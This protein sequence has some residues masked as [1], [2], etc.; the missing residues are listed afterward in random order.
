MGCLPTVPGARWQLLYLTKP[1]IVMLPGVQAEAFAA[2]LAKPDGADRLPHGQLIVLLEVGFCSDT[3]AEVK[4]QEKL[5]QHANLRETLQALGFA[6]QNHVVP[7]G[8]F[9]SVFK[10]LGSTLHAMGVQASTQNH[11]V[12]KLAANAVHYSHACLVTRRR[13][14]AEIKAKGSHMHGDMQ[15]AQKEPG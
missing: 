1:D 2:S 3:R 4:E 8:H 14:E 7:L 11:L 10:G 6:V 5:A 12:N 15:H 9:G 13:L